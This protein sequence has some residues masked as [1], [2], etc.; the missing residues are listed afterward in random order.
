M[1]AL[2]IYLL[3]VNVALVLF[4]IGYYG[5]LRKLTFYTLNRVYLVAAIL[6]STAYPFVNIDWLIQ[7]N[8]KLAVPLQPLKAVVNGMSNTVIYVANPVEHHYWNW[9][10]ATFWVGVAVMCV[11][12]LIQFWSLFNIH[13]KS[14]PA[15]IFGIPV[16]VIDVKVNPFSFWQSI[17]VNPRHYADEE[18]HSIVAHEH[19][20]VKQW[21][22]LDILLAELSLI[23]HWFNPGVWMMKKA[24]AENLEFI[25]DRS[26][27]QQGTDAKSYQYSL[28]Y[29]SLNSSPNAVV[30]HFN[31][32]TIK[33]RIMMMNSKKSSRFGLARYGFVGLIAL[34]LVLIFGTTKAAFIRKTIEKVQS[35]T[36]DILNDFSADQSASKYLVVDTAS[37]ENAPSTKP[38]E[39]LA[40]KSTVVSNAS[41]KGVDT[42]KIK[43]VPKINIVKSDTVLY[44]LDGIALRTDADFK[45]INMSEI[46]SI[47]ILKN[48]DALKTIGAGAYKQAVVMYSRKLKEGGTIQQLQQALKELSAENKSAS[49]KAQISIVPIGTGKNIQGN[50][51]DGDVLA[52]LGTLR[53][54]SPRV[55]ELVKKRDSIDKVITDEIKNEVAA[56]PKI[57]IKEKTKVPITIKVKE[58]GPETLWIIDGKASTQSGYEALNPDLIESIDVHKDKATTTYGDKGAGGVIFIKTKKAGKP[59][60]PKKIN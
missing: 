38:I 28:L 54:T 40:L 49:N 57:E 27:L 44:L 3:K 10:I 26:I 24:V 19:I 48:I 15:N 29:A 20:H 55:S 16:R 25:T 60:A 22:T 41:V 7:G 50:N 11:R 9:L 17:Y 42:P 51:N 39:Q 8:E 30:N 21:H 1:P 12:L 2:I 18:L 35:N 56:L 31:I 43:I 59:A 6:F 32:S 5:V 34:C 47:D 58:K 37:K 23:F 53:S 36:N 14:K 33:K 4:C 46:E 13:F 52:L 45:N